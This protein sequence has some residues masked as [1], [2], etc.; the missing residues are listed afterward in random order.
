M[1]FIHRVVIMSSIGF[2]IGVITGVLICAFSATLSTADGTLHLC[3]DALIASCG[4]P[5]TAFTIQAFASGI[6]GI[7]A[8]GGSTVYE[9]ESWGL[10]KCTLIHYLCTMVFYYVLGFSMRWFSISHLGEP[11]IMFIIMT[12][13][14]VAIWL[15]NFISYKIE[16]EK[17][18]RDLEELKAAPDIGL[19]AAN[20]HK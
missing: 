9:I 4:N 20:A 14:Y 16:L 18:N 3:S 13:I 12:A 17:L 11:F 2:G 5:L 15:A 1:K 10:V 6:Y 19:A 8:F 7:I